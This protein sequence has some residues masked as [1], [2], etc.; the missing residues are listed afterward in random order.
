MSDTVNLLVPADERFRA[1]GPDLAGKFCAA[2]G[3]SEAD[4]AS[5]SAAVTQAV[6]TLAP[7][8]SGEVTMDFKV[9]AGQV[10]VT[11]QCGGRSSVVTQPVPA[12]RPAT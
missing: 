3:G 12:P 2:Q 4:A 1:I 7:D 9:E 8:G 10:E 11:V 5:V 6:N